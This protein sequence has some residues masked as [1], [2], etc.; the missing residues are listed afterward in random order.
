MT[1]EQIIQ[2]ITHA[3]AILDKIKLCPPEQNIR[4]GEELYR[5][6]GQCKGGLVEVLNEIKHEN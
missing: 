4:I 1:K 2:R 3:I 6:A 5:D